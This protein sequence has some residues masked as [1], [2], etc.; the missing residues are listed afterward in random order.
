MIRSIL[1]SLMLIFTAAPTMAA[2]RN[3][4]IEFEIPEID[5][6]KKY[7]RPY[8]AIWIED[9]DRK[10]VKTV[11]LLK[12]V[13][14]PRKKTKWLDDLTK[15]WRAVGK[16]GPEAY[17]AVTSATR[18]PGV[19]SFT[20]NVPADSN[21]SILFEAAREKGGRDFVKQSI[22]N[23]PAEGLTIPAEGEIGVIKLHISQ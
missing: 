15:W 10:A 16:Q 22:N 23:I 13:S 4:N 18:N 5:S 12:E 6:W 21:W 19:Y 7:H 11:T 9:A 14:N 20:T 2:D 3:L 1:V 17:D 8:V